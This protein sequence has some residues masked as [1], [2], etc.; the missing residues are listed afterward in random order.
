MGREIKNVMEEEEEMGGSGEHGYNEH[1]LNSYA[2]E[3]ELLV[4]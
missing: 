4:A 2:C 1:P 3:F